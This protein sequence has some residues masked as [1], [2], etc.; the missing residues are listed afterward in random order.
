MNGVEFLGRSNGRISSAHVL[1]FVTGQG[2]QL[3]IKNMTQFNKGMIRTGVG[4]GRI[5]LSD[6]TA[7]TAVALPKSS[8]HV[9]SNMQAPCTF[10]SIEVQP[11]KAERVHVE[12]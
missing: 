4:R 9:L 8:L 2:Q 6:Y 11:W 5:R 3:C 10:K 7:L 1:K 12:I